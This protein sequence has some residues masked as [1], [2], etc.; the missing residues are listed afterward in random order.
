MA[1]LKSS[2]ILYNVP[3][4]TVSDFSV[5]FTYT[6]KVS[7]GD[8]PVQND[9]FSIFFIDGKTQYL[10][11]GG[12]GAGLGLVSGTDTTATSAVSGIFTSIGFDIRGNFAKKNIIPAFTTGNVT[13]VPNNLTIRLTPDFTF[14]GSII[15]P[16]P[17]LMATN[18]TN[19]I[20]IDVRN[21]FRNIN[22][23]KLYNNYYSQIASFNTTSLYN[24]NGVPSTA[25][26]G[27]GYSG[28]TVFAVQDI[29]FNY[30]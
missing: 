10:V 24:L 28:D 11:G 2:N 1:S 30:S 9:G 3:F 25:K 23:N 22:I 18:V 26:F 15:T 17:Y 4:N 6:M 12:S 7:A 27:I 5:S 8:T 14:F 16:D 19:A 29:N 20:R 13:N 21:Q